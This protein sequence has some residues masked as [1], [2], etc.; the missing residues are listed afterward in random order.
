MT[1][2]RV[3]VAADAHDERPDDVQRV[4]V[5]DAPVRLWHWVNA[6]CIFVLFITGYFIGSPLPSVPGEA[7]ANF[8]MGYIRFAHFA[9]GQVLAVFF[10]L[11]IYWAFV[12]NPH[13]RQIFYVPVWRVRFWKEWLHELAWYLFLVRRPLKYLGHNPLAQFTMF[14]MFVLP[15][16]FMIITG[17]ALYGEGAGIDSAWYAMFGWVFAI[18]PNSQDVHTYHHLGMWVIVIFTMIHIY[19]AIREDIMSRQSIVSS[20]I[21][22]ERLF[23]DRDA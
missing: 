22:G 9:A 20:M 23:R 14:L 4:Y 3:A 12:G 7:S 18:W 5:Y 13:A 10:L 15:L 16:V 1:I 19:V 11:R 2:S 17:F 6:A 21:T 8:L